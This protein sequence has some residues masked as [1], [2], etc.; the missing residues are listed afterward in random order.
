MESRAVRI[1][2]H[3]RQPAAVWSA[4]GAAYENISAQLAD[5]IEHCV[6][7]LDP[8]AGERIL[9]V[10]T[11]TG[12]AARRVAARGAEVVGIDIAESL[13]QAGRPLLAGLGVELEVADAEALPF[14]DESFDGVLSTFGVMFCSQPARAAAE[15]VRVCRPGGRIALATWLPVGTVAEMLKLINPDLPRGADATPPSPFEWGKTE[16][17]IA[18]FGHH[19]DLDFE[20]TTAHVRAASGEQMWNVFQSGF[21]PLVSA[22]ERAPAERRATLE[23]DFIAFYERFRTALGILVP[24]EYLITLGRRRSTA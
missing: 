7:R 5:A 15:M 14:P 16:R 24:R 22:F 19:C 4:G 3:N 1:L 20:Q 21:G 23:Q 13:I 18:L 10:G 12:F 11:G 6:D 9:D 8:R 2:P 17:L